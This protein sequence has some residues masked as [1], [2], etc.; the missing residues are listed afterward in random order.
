VKQFGIAF[1]AF[2][3]LVGFGQIATNAIAAPSHGYASEHGDDDHG[4]DEH[5]YVSDHGEDDH[6][7]DEHGYASD[8]GEDDH[9]D[10]DHG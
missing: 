3:T 5:G 4:D 10:D 9:G 2:A 6:G 7:D 1:L 8:H